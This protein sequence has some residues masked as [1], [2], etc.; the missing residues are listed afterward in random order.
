MT[1][2][3]T[4]AVSGTD[5][6]W[7]TDILNV[8]DL[9]DVNMTM[10]LTYDMSEPYGVLGLQYKGPTNYAAVWSLMSEM[11]SQDATVTQAYSLAC[12]STDA[13]NGSILF[14]AIDTE[15]Y[16][17][18]LMS[19]DAYYLSNNDYRTV[20][21]LASVK[22]NSSSGI[23]DLADGLP[24]SIGVWIGRQGMVVPP[25]LA[26][27]MW[28]VVGAVY[29][30]SLDAATVPCS[31]RDSEGSFVI[32]LGGDEGPTVSIPMRSLVTPETGLGENCLFMVANNTDPGNYY[33]GE[34]FLQNVYAVFDLANTKLALATP[35]ADSTTSNIVPFASASAPIPS[36]VSVASQLTRPVTE[37]PTVTEMP[38]ATAT[39]SYSAAAGFLSASATTTAANTPTSETSSTNRTTAIG[40]GVGVGVGIAA[41][42]AVGAAFFFIRRRKSQKAEPAS[43]K[44]VVL[45][46]PPN[47]FQASEPPKYQAELE[48]PHVAYELPPDAVPAELNS[49]SV[50]HDPRGHYVEL[51]TPSDMAYS[52]NPNRA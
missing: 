52:P 12:G 1:D 13:T 20:V 3:S 6:I 24:V 25:E 32:G 42:A 47:G 21:T 36:T 9:P 16:V 40:V 23:D 5:G 26:F 44:G 11:V 43:D 31:M 14:S 30:S 19:L 33:L 4:V 48:G 51:P 38:A 46:S 18:D 34:A 27:A 41:L 35:R 29:W 22:A 2:F 28:A 45:E 37:T 39:K 10:G 49:G 50:F 8:G 17:G 15:K 7:I